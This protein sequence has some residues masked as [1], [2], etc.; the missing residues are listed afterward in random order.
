MTVVG[1]WG[2]GLESDEGPELEL[3]TW[4]NDGG[5]PPRQCPF[6]REPASPAGEGEETHA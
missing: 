6:E 4:T 1:T 3:E 5:L 2:V